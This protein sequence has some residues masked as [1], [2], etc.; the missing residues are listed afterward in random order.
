[1]EARLGGYS[2]SLI[3]KGG[4][5]QA[6]AEAKRLAALANC[7]SA[8]EDAQPCG[9][10]AHCRQI[11]ADTFPYL[12]FVSPIGLSQTIQIGQI[13]ELQA[14]L[15]NKA[16]DGAY[17]VAV[18]TE[19]HRMREDSQNCFL[20]TL[21]EPPGRTLL[22]LLT[23]KPEDLLDTVRS[24]CQ[25]ADFREEDT[26]PS[27]ADKELALDVLWA[28]QADGYRGVFERAAFVA[29]SK[30]KDMPGFLGALEL[31][32]H[33]GLVES[34]CGAPRADA[35]LQGLDAHFLAALGLVWRAGY[36]VERNVNTLLLL[37]N[38]FL[39]LKPLRI[40]VLERGA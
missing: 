4:S 27:Q 37:E 31:L 19:A 3:I 30:K 20:K 29:G 25:V 26:Q 36:L 2:Q 16:A 8:D 12:F 32:L 17:K 7:Q 39:Q 34:M 14:E 9:I 40:Q 23:D 11:A 5:E 6:L 22:L 35:V 10:C 24:R 28:L 15:S 13:R 1:M 18:L 38:L 21:E 33:D